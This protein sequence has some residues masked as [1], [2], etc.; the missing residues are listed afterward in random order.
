MNE[1]NAC[2]YD[3]TYSH[4]NCSCP[5]EGS[6]SNFNEGGFHFLE[7]NENL[8]ADVTNFKGAKCPPKKA[9]TTTTTTTNNTDPYV[10]MGIQK[11]LKSQL[12]LWN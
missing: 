4:M 5:L 3:A 10:C 2:M 12:T 9:K 8:G 11:L 7:I 6:K 1:M